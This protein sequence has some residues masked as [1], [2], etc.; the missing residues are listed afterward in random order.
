[1]SDANTVKSSAGDALSLRIAGIDRPK[2][3]VGQESSEIGQRNESIGGYE[4]RHGR[5][6]PIEVVGQSTKKRPEMNRSAQNQSRNASWAYYPGASNAVA[7][8][9]NASAR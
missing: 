4:L 2:Q 5:Y 6:S 9:T 8:Q 3:R 7:G 1:M